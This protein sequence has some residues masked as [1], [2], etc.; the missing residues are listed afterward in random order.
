M[1]LTESLVEEAWV[2]V[3]RPVTVR[4]PES[5]IEERVAAPAVRL[6]A[7]MLMVPKPEAMEPEMRAPTEVRE[8]P[9]IP[10]PRVVAERTLVPLI[11]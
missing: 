4:V 7:P 3:E 10:E 1:S 8:D 2:K 11:W 5:E 6:L 9:V